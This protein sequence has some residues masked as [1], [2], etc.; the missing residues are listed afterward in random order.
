MPRSIADFGDGGAF[1]EIHVAQYPLGMG[2]K[3]DKA[4][5]QKGGVV[6][7]EVGEDGSV[8]Y[9]AIV[10]QGANKNRIVQTSLKDTKG[11]AVGDDEG[12]ELPTE[13]EVQ[14]TAQRTQ[15]ALSVIL[16]GKVNSSKPTHIPEQCDPNQQ[17]ATFVRYTPNPNAPGYTATAAQRIVKLVDQQV[18]PMEPPK[19]KH[20][21]VPRGPPSPP[22]PVLHSPPRKVSHS[23]QKMTLNLPGSRRRRRRGRQ[24]SHAVS[25]RRP[26]HTGHG[27]R[28]AVLEDPALRLELEERARVHDS[29]R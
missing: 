22:A 1:P 15:Q 21:K 29:P 23:E 11:R 28:P 26:C 18:D 27:P 2:T 25:R 10:K 6:A 12:L 8:R 4:A 17:K 9:D 24:R 7:L 14:E 16:D 13:E 19:H 20:T 5:Q 3:E